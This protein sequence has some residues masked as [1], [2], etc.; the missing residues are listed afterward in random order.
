[1]SHRP[2]WP[3]ILLGLLTACASAPRATTG[4]TTAG[5]KDRIEGGRPDTSGILRFVGRF[6]LAHG[7]P[8]GDVV[9]TA[10]HVIDPRPF[11]PD[12]PLLPYRYSDGAGNAGVV[13]PVSTERCADLGVMAV[14][15]GSVVRP[16]P[17]AAAEPRPGD[18][19]WYVGYDWSGK[20][21]A[22]AEKVYHAEVIRVVAGHLVLDEAG[23][24]GSSG[25]CVLNQAGEVV[26]INTWGRQVGMGDEVE[27]VVGIWGDWLGS[28]R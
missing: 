7:C 4:M 22:F 18:R 15:P 9:L 24:V 16:Y 13:A 21:R 27:G 2:L 12:V 6:N 26:A 17:R 11:E 5:G 10:A 28:C 25:S 3:A 14:R 1:M 23:D 20:K 8:V 19:V